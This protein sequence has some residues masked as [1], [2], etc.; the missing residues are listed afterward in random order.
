[1][2]HPEKCPDCGKDLASFSD[3]Q[4]FGHIGG[5]KRRKTNPQSQP[6]TPNAQKATFQ[7]EAA[8]PKNLGKLEPAKPTKSPEKIEAATTQGLEDIVSLFGEIFNEWSDPNKELKITK[9]DT[10]RITRAI[11]L[12]DAKYHFG[13]EGANGYFPEIFAAIVIGVVAYKGLTIMASRGKPKGRATTFEKAER[14]KESGEQ[15]T[16]KAFEIFDRPEVKA[17]IDEAFRTAQGR[18]ADSKGVSNYVQ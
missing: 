8:E 1:M 3:S 9:E 17:G 14:L 16:D 7:V 15:S 4:A 18:T 10:D 5:H 6:N 12:L 13:V 11:D 2:T